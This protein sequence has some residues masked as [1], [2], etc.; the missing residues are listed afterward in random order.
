[1]NITIIE[2]KPVEYAI[3]PHDHWRACQCGH[4][5]HV[6]ADGDYCEQCGTELPEPE[7]E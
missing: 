6:C 5:Q 2:V 7:R 4:L 3:Q 1:M